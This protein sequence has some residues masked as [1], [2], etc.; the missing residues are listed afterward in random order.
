MKP[1]RSALIGLAAL[2]EPPELAWV[3]TE[4]QS[5]VGSPFVF[6]DDAAMLSA[7]GGKSVGDQSLHAGPPTTVDDRDI[8]P[9][10]SW[11]ANLTTPDEDSFGPFHLASGDASTINDAVPNHVPPR[12]EIDTGSPFHIGG[13]VTGTFS[14]VLAMWPNPTSS[15]GWATGS[16]PAH[17]ILGGIPI[18]QSALNEASITL[19]GNGSA[20]GHTLNA[21]IDTHIKFVGPDGPQPV[22]EIPSA[23]SSHLA[24]SE[25]PLATGTAISGIDIANVSTNANG[26][27]TETVTFA[28]SGIVFN[29][30]FDA[31][32]SQP[33][34]NCVLSA[35]QAIATEWTNPVTIN[36]EFSAQA[37]GLDGELASNQFYVYGVSYATIKGALITL[38]AQE[39]SNSYLQQAVAHLPSTDPS[40]G[41]GFELALPYG[42]ILGLTPT[43]QNPDDIVILNTSYNW[44][45]GQD[46]IN[47]VE[48]EISEGGMGRI[49]GLGDQNGFWSVMDLF[50]YNAS[51]LADYSDGRDG[52]TTYFSYN[53]GAALSSLSFN[54]QFNSLGQQ[55]NGGDTADFVQQDVFGIGSPGETNAL[56]Q[57]DI[58]VMDALGW[59]PALPPPVVTATDQTVAAGQS[60]PFSSIYSISGSDITEYQVWFSWPEGGD[61]AD[62]T[63]TNNGTPIAKDQWVTFSSLSGLAFVG[64]TTAGTDHIWLRAYN[65]AWNNPSTEAIITDHGLVPPVVTAT[66]QTVAAGQSLPFSSIYSVSGSDIT[67]YQVWFSWPEGGDPADGTVTNNGTPIAKD[68]WVTFSSLSGLA[69]VGSTTAGTDHIWLRAYNGSWN[70][71]STEAIITDHGLAPPVVTA[72][73]KTVAA[74]QSV[75]LSSIYSISGSDITEYQVWFSW[76]EG[77]DPAD[78]T[79]TNNG[80][81]IAKDQWFTF[82]SLSGLAFVGSTT[83]GTDHI[84]LRAYNGAWNNPSTEAI[85]TDQGA[86]TI[87][88]VG[89]D[90]FLFKATEDIERNLTI[91]P[92]AEHHDVL[93]ASGTDALRIV[94]DTPHPDQPYAHLDWAMAASHFQG[95]LLPPV[96]IS[97]IHGHG[98]L[99]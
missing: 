63:V 51:G 48:H 72:T 2:G 23:G 61:P 47:T 15:S 68:Q 18:I 14:P 76:P 67:E 13:F 31:S 32:V 92:P 77:G 71:P 30:T 98:F 99:I 5:S 82:S 74:G 21:I 50:R 89:N 85:I 52:H 45:Y 40:G 62:G 10:E 66:D 60:L 29:D 93:S 79:V 64:S 96:S 20:L 53:G 36:E 65:G 25:R 28:G 56:S 33:Y 8:Q 80:T 57:T 37:Q 22:V 3:T 41:S 49:G 44:S 58:Q 55:V 95:G 78:G 4:E 86:A 43:T 24:A 42:R 54:N 97:D 88:G 6:T 9:I 59:D 38:A 81:P 91:P 16:I 26:S 19:Q 70:N 46:V 35:E 84:W 11:F 17:D 90:T 94:S 69:F 83:A 7:V 39:P 1:V 87:G 73:N 12:V 75:P 34:K 27:T